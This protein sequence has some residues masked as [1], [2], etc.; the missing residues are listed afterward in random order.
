MKRTNKLSI[1][2]AMLM[3][4]IMGIV[5]VTL[6][7]DIMVGDVSNSDCSMTTRAE[8]IAGHTTLKLT[9]SEIGLVGELRN[10]AVNCGYGDVKVLC[11][12]DGDNLTIVIDDG[13]NQFLSVHFSNFFHLCNPLLSH[14]GFGSGKYSLIL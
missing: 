13:C 12:E 8:G 11:E 1:R 9:R 3:I 7:D 2:I 4:A 5:N 6:A 14:C 10:F